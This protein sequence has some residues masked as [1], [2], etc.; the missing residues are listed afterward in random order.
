MSPAPAAGTYQRSAGTVHD[1]R[2]VPRK[3]LADSFRVSPGP[4][5]G[6]GGRSGCG[7]GVLGHAGLLGDSLLISEATW[8]T[9]IC[10]AI[11][12][13]GAGM[14]YREVGNLGAKG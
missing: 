12:G 9:S 13:F 2:Q 1:Q 14:W 8:A 11:S 6:S 4:G 10:T 7:G 5:P 3:R